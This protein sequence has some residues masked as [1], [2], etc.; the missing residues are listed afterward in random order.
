MV[1]L[2]THTYLCGHAVGTPADYAAQSVG[3]GFAVLGI[4]DHVPFPDDRLPGI[5]MPYSKLGQYMEEICRARQQHPQMKILAAAECEYFPELYSYYKDELLGNMHMDYLI[6]SV[7][8]FSSRGSVRG[9][10][11]GDKMDREDLLSYAESYAE[12]LESG[13]F[14]FGAHPDTFGAAIGSWDENC[15]ECAERICHAA[16][17]T[18]M[19]L[20]V[21]TSGWVKQ[22]QH[23]EL[24][25]PYPLK[26][27]WETAA[28]LGVKA[29]V[30]SDA[31]AP[32]LIDAYLTDGYALAHEAGVEVV[33]PMG[34]VK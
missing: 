19:P 16:V 17:K 20:E 33:Y 28:K 1:N 32:E 7:H 30:N 14:L 34:N 9:F 4:S 2:H 3:K 18:G 24:P 27:F 13:L 21:N 22:G 10:W 26:E 8:F 5:R 25:R 31:H 15:R 11:E 6:G 12:M 29:V 23:P